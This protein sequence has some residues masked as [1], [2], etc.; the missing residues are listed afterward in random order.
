MGQRDRS[1][2]RHR[3]DMI[4]PPPRAGRTAES[5]A[6]IPTT[7]LA[8]DLQAYIGRQLRAVYD[9]VL[10]EPVPERF[11]SLLRELDCKSGKK[12]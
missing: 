6:A 8:A 11:L 9:E 5:P 3:Q 12:P 2:P 10:R 1:K 4:N 7:A